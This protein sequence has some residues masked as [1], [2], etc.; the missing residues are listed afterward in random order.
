ML[1]HGLLGRDNGE[2]THLHVIE[3]DMGLV[4]LDL[5]QAG[6]DGTGG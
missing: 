6:D 2:E 3:G 5:Q 4:Y 1:V